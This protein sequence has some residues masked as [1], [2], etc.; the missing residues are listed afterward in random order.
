MKRLLAAV[1][2]PAVLVAS[3]AALTGCSGDDQPAAGEQA[4]ATTSPSGAASPQD[5]GS[6]GASP[7]SPGASTSA[8]A[9]APGAGTR[10]C[11]LL[12]SDLAVLFSSIQG[13][14]D[15]QK[16]VGVVRDIADEAPP[17]VADEWATMSGALD[18]LESALR[19]AAA[20]QQKAADGE[21]SQ[22]KLQKQSARLMDDM[23]KLDTPAN[24]EAGDAVVAH[25]QEYC[26][27][28]LG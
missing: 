1:A 21:I 15:V 4:S 16:A 20:L 17:E 12:S 18:Q 3:A 25:A 22:K 23:K 14:E 9:N 26:G 8:Q 11:T 2:A 13:P 7:Q 10:Y 6:S 24:N 27:V 28:K 19:K 5:G